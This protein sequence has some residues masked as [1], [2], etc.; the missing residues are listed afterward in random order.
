[1]RGE[2]VSIIQNSKISAYHHHSFGKHLLSFFL[3]SF[4]SWR[5]K[6]TYTYNFIVN[7]KLMNEHAFMWFIQREKCFRVN[8]YYIR[9]RWY[10]K[11]SFASAHP[12]THYLFRSFLLDKNVQSG[13]DDDRKKKPTRR[14]QTKERKKKTPLQ[15]LYKQI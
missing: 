7:N 3:C 13:N 8:V 4:C 6:A 2:A 15:C 12:S 14:K 5:T 10:A 11:C 1:M 9:L